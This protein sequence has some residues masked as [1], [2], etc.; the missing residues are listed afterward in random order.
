MDPPNALELRSP[1][2]PTLGVPG[3]ALGVTLGV[4]PRVGYTKSPILSTNRAISLV[5]TAYRKPSEPS[6]ESQSSS[7]RPTKRRMRRKKRTNKGSDK[8]STL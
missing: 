3:E 4:K 7:E 5:G 6:Y 2:R 1:H 8:G